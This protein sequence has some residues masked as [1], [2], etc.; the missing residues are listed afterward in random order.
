MAKNFLELEARMSRERRARIN[1]EVKK[2]LAEM[3]NGRRA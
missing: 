2:T 3:P 1:E